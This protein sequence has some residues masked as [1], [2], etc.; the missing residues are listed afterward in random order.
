MPLYRTTVTLLGWEGGPGVSVLH[1]EAID[2]TAVGQIPGLINSAYTN[3]RHNLLDDMQIQTS[4]E[5]IEIDA[6]TGQIRDV[7]SVSP[8]LAVV[9]TGVGGGIP[10][11]T[12]ANVRHMTDSVY[13]G[14]RLNGRTFVGPLAS[15]ALDANGLITSAAAGEFSTM[16]DGLQDLSGPRLMVYH[17]PREATA[18][19]PAS[20]GYAAHVQR[21]ECL[22][23]P[24]NL[25]SRRD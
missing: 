10:R 18:D 8:T 20:A 9:C 11:G 3:V 24:G 13:E 5:M 1:F 4:I 16:W 23:K 6:A 17:R 7:I 14:K 25:R 22:R 2:E 12:C 21:S 19:R 15:A